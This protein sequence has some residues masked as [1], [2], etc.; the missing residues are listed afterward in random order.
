MKIR[1]EGKRSTK[2]ARWSKNLRDAL[3]RPP[4]KSNNSSITVPVQGPGYCAFDGPP[5]P[6]PRTPTLSHRSDNNDVQPTRLQN[7]TIKRDKTTARRRQ[8]DAGLTK[9]NTAAR[10]RQKGPGVGKRDGTKTTQRSRRSG[11]TFEEGKARWSK[12]LA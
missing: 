10:R 9:A 11:R 4:P 6:P 5:H 12:T 3:P 2:G 1:A 8:N 7:I